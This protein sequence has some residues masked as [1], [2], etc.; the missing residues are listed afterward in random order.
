MTAARSAFAGACVLLAGCGGSTVEEA[1]ATPMDRP[2][3]A[4][5]A[6]TLPS[7]SRDSSAT[8]DTLASFT[9]RVDGDTARMERVELAVELGAGATGTLTAWRADSVWQRIHLVAGD[10]AFR[11]TDTYWLHDAKPVVARLASQRPQQQPTV[12]QVWLRDGQL[13]RW[14]DARGRHLSPEAQSTRTEVEMLTARVAR[15]LDALPAAQR[16]VPDQRR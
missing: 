9:A 15:L 6:L 14:V 1:K 8:L 5:V 2:H 4:P 11:T 13:Y 7:A 16:T 3:L 10:S 12:E